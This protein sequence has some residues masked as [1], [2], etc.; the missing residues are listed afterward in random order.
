MTAV[1][2][3]GAARDITIRNINGRTVLSPQTSLTHKN[4]DQLETLFNGLLKREVMEMVVD[5]TRVSFLDSRALELIVDMQTQLQT[6]GGNLGLSNL[7]EV[8][9]DILI[10]VRLINRFKVMANVHGSS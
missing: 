7:N 2:S 4:C 1:A 3:S 10:C 6:K 5:F 9:R 8:C